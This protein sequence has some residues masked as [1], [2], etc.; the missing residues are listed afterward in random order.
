MNT[1]KQYEVTIHLSSDYKVIV[2][3]EDKEHAGELAQ[4]YAHYNYSYNGVCEAQLIVERGLARL[5]P[6]DEAEVVEAEVMEEVEE[7]KGN[8][9]GTL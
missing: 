2:N 1:L 8:L 5:G 7:E 3:A 6:N 9:Y 4:E